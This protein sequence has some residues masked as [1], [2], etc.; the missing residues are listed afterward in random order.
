MDLL[1]GLVGS[2]GLLSRKTGLIYFFMTLVWLSKG[3]LSAQPHSTLHLSAFGA[4]D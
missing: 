3:L 2:T 1:V 4:Q